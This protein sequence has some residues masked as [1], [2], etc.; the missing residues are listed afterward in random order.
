ML[1][2]AEVIRITAA[3]IFLILAIPAIW[4]WIKVFRIS[5]IKLR[6]LG[7][8]IRHR[9]RARIR[10]SIFNLLSDEKVLQSTESRRT[11]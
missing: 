3:L 4:W 5:R 8:E 10:R 6:V 2:H 7:R 11:E 9:I 1:S